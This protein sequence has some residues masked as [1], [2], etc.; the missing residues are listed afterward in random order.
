M[1]ISR[2]WVQLEFPP[3]SWHKG[4][5]SHPSGGQGEHPLTTYLHPDRTVLQG[6]V[7][8]RST[9]APWRL[10][11]QEQS[12]KRC[13]GHREAGQGEFTKGRLKAINVVDDGLGERDH[14]AS[15]QNAWHR[16][17]EPQTESQVNIIGAGKRSSWMFVRVLNILPG[18]YCA[19]IWKTYLLL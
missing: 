2:D 5:S 18:N 6:T 3:Y 15:K 13:W 16:H 1:A 7:A 9:T 4:W 8:G 10:G 19:N 11:C 14:F 12:R 17:I